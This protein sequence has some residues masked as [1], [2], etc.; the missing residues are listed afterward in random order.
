MKT[1]VVKCISWTQEVKID[2]KL[3][4][5][6]MLEAC[7]RAV[8]IHFKDNPKIIT[9]VLHCHLK[10]SKKSKIHTYNSYI[11]LINAAYYNMAEFL[12]LKFLKET[13]I[14]LAK[15]PVKA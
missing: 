14:D 3:F 2:E 12:R 10:S 11:I 15:E 5:D 7:T 6:Y 13:A 8:E 4:D 1:V 9:P